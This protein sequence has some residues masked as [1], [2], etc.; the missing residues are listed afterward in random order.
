ML[1][2][3]LHTHTSDDPRDLIAHDAVGLIDR[4]A[5]LGFQVLAITLHDKQFDVKEVA[6]HA[7]DRGIVLVPGIERTLHGKHLLLLN[8]PPAAERVTSFD[9]VRR[10]KMRSN[11]VVIA[12]HPFFPW[13]TCLRSALRANPDLCDA[14]ELNA[15][16]TRT[17]D[18]NRPARRFA[19]A[20]GKPVVGNAD[21]HRLSQ[22]GTTFSLIDAEP[23]ADAVCTAIR[24][25][26]VRTESR[27]LTLVRAVTLFGTLVVTDLWGRLSARRE[28]A[29][30]KS[31]S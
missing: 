14:V 12:P 18:F 17:F 11:G 29:I 4:A 7:R 28:P 21:V 15:F 22:L 13:P 2:S 20:H 5:E 26:R 9:E 19:E 25:G 16:Y 8:F 10:L 6:S 23:E 31:L 3:E 24:E 27:P 30:E 1:K